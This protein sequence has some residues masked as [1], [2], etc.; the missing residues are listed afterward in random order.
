MVVRKTN[1]VMQKLDVPKRMTL[2][3]GRT[4]LA[5][6]KRINRRDLPANIRMRRTYTQAA[7]PRNRKR[8]P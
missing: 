4:F 3:N 1:Y 7:A 6:Y 2:P 5:R 8:N